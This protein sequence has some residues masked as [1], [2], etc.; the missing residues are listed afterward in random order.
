MKSYFKKFMALMLAVLMVASCLSTA[1]FAVDDVAPAHEHVWVE[2]AVVAPTCTTVGYT[3]EKC[4]C[5]EVQEKAGSIVL[6]TGHPG[7]EWDENNA[8]FS[9]TACGHIK[10]WNDGIVKH[11]YEFVAVTVLPTCA[12]AG[13]ALFRCDG[14][15]NCDCTVEAPTEI[16]EE[17]AKFDHE[18]KLLYADVTSCDEDAEY[19]VHYECANCGEERKDPIEGRPNHVWGEWVKSE[20]CLCRSSRTCKVCGKVETTSTC[21]YT[22]K[23]G[24]DEGNPDTALD[25]RCTLIYDCF[26]CGCEDCMET[27]RYLDEMDEYKDKDGHRAGLSVT[28]SIL[29]TCETWGTDI[30][31]CL[32]CGY[33]DE[34]VSVKPVGHDWEEEV[35]LKANCDMPG[36]KQNVCQTC[37]E[38]VAEIIPACGH[39]FP[40]SADEDWM[41]FY[42]APTC[43]SGAIWEL[44]CRHSVLTEEESKYYEPCDAM[45]DVID[46]NNKTPNPNNHPYHMDGV[47]YDPYHITTRPTCVA[48]GE[49][50]IACSLCNTYETVSYEQMVAAEAEGKNYGKS[51]D[52]I[53][54]LGHDPI[55][56][57]FAGNCMSPAVT[58]TTCSRCADLHEVVEGEKNYSVHAVEG[59]AI[60]E[61]L[62][63]P[64]DINGKT[65]FRTPTGEA[66]GIL[67]LLCPACDRYYTQIDP[68]TKLDG[69][70]MDANG[71]GKVDIYDGVLVDE[72]QAPTCTEPGYTASYVVY[73]QADYYGSY[74]EINE[75]TGKTEWHV[76]KYDCPYYDIHNVEEIPALG[77]DYINVIDHLNATCTEP[78]HTAGWECSRCDEKLESTEIDAL[79]HALVKIDAKDPTCEKSGNIE[80]H[81]CS[82][83]DYICTYNKYGDEIEAKL[84]DVIIPAVGHNFELA[85]DSYCYDHF[86]AA[87]CVTNGWWYGGICTNENCDGGKAFFKNPDGSYKLFPVYNE[88]DGSFSHWID[89]VETEDGKACEH[90]YTAPHGHDFVRGT[91]VANCEQPGLTY[92]ICNYCCVTEEG[93]LDKCDMVV[94]SDYVAPLAHT[95]EDV[96][97]EPTCTEPGITGSVCSVCGTANGEIVETPAL[98]HDV[99]LHS[100]ATR[101]IPCDRCGVD[102][103]VHEGM[104]RVLENLNGY[105]ALDPVDD[106]NCIH[107]DITIFYCTGCDKTFSEDANARILP[108]VFG[109]PVEDLQE[110]EYVYTC[111]CGY[112]KREPMENLLFNSNVNAAL[113]QDGTVTILDNSASV[114]S[115]LVAV[116]VMVS[117]HEID[118]WGVE[119]ALNYNSDLLT[120]EAAL[121]RDYNV[122]NNNNMFFEFK[123]NENGTVRIVAAHTKNNPVDY[124]LTGVEEFVTLIFRVNYDKYNVFADFAIA[125]GAKVIEADA[126]VVDKCVFNSIDSEY[127]YQL[128]DVRKDTQGVDIFDA[129]AL[130]EMLFDGADYEAVADID[131]NGVIDVDDFVYLQA[132]IADIENYDEFFK[133]AE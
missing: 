21:E 51:S 23:F 19:F 62:G 133:P 127:I 118:F 132:L 95:W 100:A 2:W 60:P 87:G 105:Q 70:T 119:M 37:G 31:F 94:I 53:K 4:E 122:A 48:N 56:D 27:V 116:Q 101:F 55:V 123:D 32:Y 45:R 65:Y 36:R 112:E 63:T 125:D 58:T 86:E 81:D 124:T 61:L 49:L 104:Y 47:D 85:S 54:A 24:Y 92:V 28:H 16:N 15:D 66:D 3:L 88:E 35:L 99:E 79:G 69:H 38:T 108:H 29:P 76:K 59:I 52:E 128:G 98:G 117:G 129:Q 90:E 25:N 57:V 83:C 8:V 14:S 97:T 93:K 102:V 73:C 80:Y 115:G 20:T 6:A 41:D 67:Y 103:D 114:N 89:Y 68:D 107:Y 91:E 22:E 11:N 71:D 120:Y 33:R 40:T 82:R 26:K 44:H 74:Y 5:G 126:D 30:H 72:A 131:K 110:F 42:K 75:E 113:E 7:Y 39:V 50:S 34:A 17:I 130:M 78:G 10:D 46:E 12:V 13:N 96:D 1:V 9:C 64:V 106:E 84:A 18:W 43:V 121:T 111:G 109:E 77:H